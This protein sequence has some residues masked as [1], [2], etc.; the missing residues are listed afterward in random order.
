MDQLEYEK[1]TS[2]EIQYA[3]DNCGGDWMAQAAI[4]AQ[5]YMESVP[6]S[7]DELISQLEYEKFTHEEAVH[8]VDAVG[9]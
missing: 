8:G 7:R 2:E 1:F 4:K 5:S 3:I 9:L 6:M